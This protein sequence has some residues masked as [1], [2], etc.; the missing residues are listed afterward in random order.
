MHTYWWFQLGQ[1]G[2]RVVA[3][4]EQAAGREVL[5]RRRRSGVVWQRGSGREASLK[6]GEASRVLN[7]CGGRPE[8]GAPQQ[9]RAPA[10]AM[11]G[12]GGVLAE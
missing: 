8:L 4:R 6:R 7:L 1:R 3:R 12:G 9:G 10:A 2:P 5:R 11:V